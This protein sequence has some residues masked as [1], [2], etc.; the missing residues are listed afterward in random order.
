LEDNHIFYIFFIRIKGWIHFGDLVLP[1]SDNFKGA[2][3]GRVLLQYCQASNLLWLSLEN[4]QTKQDVGVIRLR[5]CT[6]N[7]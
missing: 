1:Y 3:G 4:K 6:S 7:K 2:K 5:H